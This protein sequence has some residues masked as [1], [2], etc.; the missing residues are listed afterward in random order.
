MS[1]RSIL[2]AKFSDGSIKAV[3]VH[4]DGYGHLPTLQNN[5]NTQEK[6]EALIS[7]GDMSSLYESLETCVFYRRDWKE[8]EEGTKLTDL[9]SFDDLDDLDW[10]QEFIYIWD[11][12]GWTKVDLRDPPKKSEDE[13]GDEEENIVVCPHCGNSFPLC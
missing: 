12:S 7:L 8:K 9:E 4:H 1:T 13:S 11:G 5:Y 2:A 10:G 6:V 3:Y